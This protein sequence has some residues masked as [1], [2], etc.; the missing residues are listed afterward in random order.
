[1]TILNSL[2]VQKKFFG[3]SPITVTVAVRIYRVRKK[4]TVFPE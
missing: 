1:M 2:L 4:P 3:L